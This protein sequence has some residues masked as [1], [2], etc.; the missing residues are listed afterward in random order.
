MRG[1]R[2]SIGSESKSNS[3]K[4]EG[5]I[6]RIHVVGIEFD[7]L[8]T[9]NVRGEFDDCQIAIEAL[10]VAAVLGVDLDT[11]R[12]SCFSVVQ[13]NVSHALRTSYKQASV[14]S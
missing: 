12:A 14:K 9:C 7:G 8:H 4:R 10:S 1:C 2:P 11:S 13:V 5:L 3:R 6:C